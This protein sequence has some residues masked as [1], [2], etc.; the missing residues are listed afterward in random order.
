M[1][2]LLKALSWTF[3]HSLWQ[4]L[5]AAILAAI[6][7]SATK[8]ASARLRYNLLGSALLLFL[9][10]TLFTFQQQL[11]IQR[12]LLNADSFAG[13][14]LAS[15][16][17]PVV[18]NDSYNA[19]T[20]IKTWFNDNAGM[21]VLAWAVFFLVNCLRLVTG[22]ATVSRLRH[23]KTKPVTAE[24][25]TKL[26]DLLH[27]M[28]M[29]QV[30]TLLQSGLVSVPVALGV[31]KPVILV[32]IGLLSNIPPEQAE[33]ILLHELAH[34]RRKDY[35]VNLIQRFVDAIFFFN[36]AIVWISS[37]LRQER[38]A[39][40][41]DMVVAST[42]QKRNYVN[43][44]VSFQEYALNNTR[45]VM[46]I[47]SKRHYLLNRVKRIMTNENKRLNIA[48][49]LVLFAGL[50]LFCA[51]TVIT[52]TKKEVAPASI[53]LNRL[54][55]IDAAAIMDPKKLNPGPVA[56]STIKKE[57]N[58]PTPVNKASVDTI[59]HKKDSI[60]VIKGK[61]ET[62]WED[63]DGQAKQALKDIEKIKEKIGMQ[64]EAIGIQKEKLKNN[65]TN[66]KETEERL[67]QQRAD[68]ERDR[69][70]LE[71]KRSEWEKY[72]KQAQEEK[73]DND[74]TEEKAKQISVIKEKVKNAAAMSEK[75]KQE[76]NQRVKEN[77]DRKETPRTEFPRRQLHEPRT[78]IHE[79]KTDIHEPIK[80]VHHPGEPAPK[81][82][83]TT[84]LFSDTKRT[85]I[86]SSKKIKL[87]PTPPL[88][89]KLFT[90]KQDI[91]WQN[92]E[93]KT[94]GQW[95]LKPTT[96]TPKS[97]PES[98]KQENPSPTAPKKKPEPKQADL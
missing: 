25:E 92:K 82:E 47:G 77:I 15:T 5:L 88:K 46:A 26:R 61:K 85:N 67:K 76:L 12:E 90:L 57:R 7:I 62:K 84:R 93:Y 1:Q 16:L 2:V 81:K 30:V 95:E 28:N 20:V 69:S 70:E 36:P 83:S 32:P 33:A 31:L 65:D 4:G 60:I 43:A 86:F 22:L 79:P 71:K 8:K 6:I 66:K 23:Y 29:R 45:Y 89:S 98:K 72:K 27:K 53:E 40:C 17:Y 87:D 24:W 10:T 42:G 74:Q 49:T 9:A 38:E 97:P 19:G 13:A 37:L 35:L 41:D 64:K 58:R 78:T 50:I 68:L 51:F 14:A 91:N 94:D 73:K 44:L 56:S 55:T 54:A 11:V 63:A 39:C 75:D 80:E 52:K 96:V 59:P 3:L 34:I 48:E 18:Y 21:V